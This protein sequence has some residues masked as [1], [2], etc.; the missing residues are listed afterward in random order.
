[1]TVMIYCVV[2]VFITISTTYIVL[3]HIACV[4]LQLCLIPM[5]KC[6]LGVMLLF[7]LLIKQNLTFFLTNYC[8]LFCNKK[9]I[10]C[11]VHIFGS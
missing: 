9:K 4:F 3:D 1:M 7:I 11:K 5:Y 8:I 10:R 6:L 2:Q